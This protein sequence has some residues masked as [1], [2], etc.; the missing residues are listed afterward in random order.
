MTV[1]IASGTAEASS[2]DI[3][4]ADGQSTNLCL[5]DGD[6]PGVTN[7]AVALVQYKSAGGV[8]ITIGRLTRE[9]PLK[10]LFGPG[11]FKVVRLKSPVAFG[12]DRD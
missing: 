6:A 7:Q 10:R 4:L 2:A 8:Y 1:L 9:E 5:V 11:T 12:V 3:V